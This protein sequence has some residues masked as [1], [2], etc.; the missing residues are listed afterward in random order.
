MMNEQQYKDIR[1]S[2]DYNE[3]ILGKIQNKIDYQ[4]SKKEQFQSVLDEIEYQQN[5]LD[6]AIDMNAFKRECFNFLNRVERTRERNAK[7]LKERQELY[8]MAGNLNTAWAQLTGDS[9]PLCD[10]LTLKATSKLYFL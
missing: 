7:S 8:N 3:S 2:L 1:L 5:V 10:P 6:L 9:M 4:L